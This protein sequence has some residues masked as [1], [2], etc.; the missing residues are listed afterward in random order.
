MINDRLAYGIFGALAAV[1]CA[2][3]YLLR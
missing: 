3:L 1:G 2:V